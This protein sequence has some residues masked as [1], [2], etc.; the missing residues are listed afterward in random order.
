VKRIR[1][2]LHSGETRLATDTE[3]SALW[4]KCGVWRPL[5]AR[6][7]RPFGHDPFLHRGSQ[8]NSC[9]TCDSAHSRGRRTGSAN[10][11]KSGI[12]VS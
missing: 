5:H 6:S 11:P 9:P 2:R 1:T 10:F 7:T 4:K 3:V 8:S 12:E